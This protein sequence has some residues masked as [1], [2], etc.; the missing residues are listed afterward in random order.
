MYGCAVEMFRVS[1]FREVKN[2]VDSL[3]DSSDSKNLFEEHTKPA[4]LDKLV[5]DSLNIKTLKAIMPDEY[6]MKDVWL[7]IDYPEDFLLV[8]YLASQVV[9]RHSFNYT[10]RDLMR[11]IDKTNSRLFI[12][13]E[14]HNGFG[15]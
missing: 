13:K 4:F 1:K 11:T 3:P 8:S 10:H 14:L 5:S 12:N 9:E 2:Y 15:E 7:S 6:R